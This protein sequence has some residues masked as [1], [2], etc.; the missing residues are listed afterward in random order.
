MTS[1]LYAFAIGTT[2]HFVYLL[3]FWGGSVQQSCL[4][5]DWPAGPDRP[6]YSLLLGQFCKTK[7]VLYTVKHAYKKVP[8]R[9]NLSLIL[10]IFSVYACDNTV[11]WLCTIQTNKLR[12]SIIGAQSGFTYLCSNISLYNCW[13]LYEYNKEI[14]WM[15]CGDNFSRGLIKFIIKP[16]WL[17]WI[18][19]RPNQKINS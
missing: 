16:F 18:W 5:R 4:Y 3:S 11:Y 14:L 19:L 8:R 7:H 6:V 15:L 9:Y 12:W 1:Y 13:K 10:T 2:D 17:Y